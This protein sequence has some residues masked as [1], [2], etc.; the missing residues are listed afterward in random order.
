MIMSDI[1]QVKSVETYP[2]EWKVYP[3]R[4]YAEKNDI[5][6]YHRTRKSAQNHAAE[7]NRIVKRREN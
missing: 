5:S 1:W 4:K 6:M 2:A 3:T 7:L